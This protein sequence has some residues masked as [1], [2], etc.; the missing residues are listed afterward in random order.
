MLNRET[1]RPLQGHNNTLHRNYV[2]FNYP[3]W[4]GLP[5]GSGD[6]GGD[7]LIWSLSVESGRMY[8][9]ILD[10]VLATD[11]LFVSTTPGFWFCIKT[12]FNF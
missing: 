6:E 2:K 8:G 12:S 3:T 9:M 1:D 11:V 4:L 7:E 10:L 5:D